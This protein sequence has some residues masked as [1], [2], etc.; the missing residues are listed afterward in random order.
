M[1]RRGIC[2]VCFTTVTVRQDGLIRAHGYLKEA[3]ETVSCA[4]TNKEPRETSEGAFSAL[5]LADDCSEPTSAIVW[6]QDQW[7][8]LCKQDAVKALS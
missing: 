8:S 2:P 6:T 1:R 4:G 5:C 3:G 7:L